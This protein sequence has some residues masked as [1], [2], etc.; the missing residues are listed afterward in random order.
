MNNQNEKARRRLGKK[1]SYISLYENG[2]I[3]DKHETEIAE[4]KLQM[5]D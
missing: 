3:L 4:L 1:V 5:H 2:L